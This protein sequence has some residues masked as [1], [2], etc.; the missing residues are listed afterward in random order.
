MSNY[1]RGLGRAVSFTKDAAR[2]GL[3]EDP[4]DAEWD[5]VSRVSSR[6]DVN[7]LRGG[8]GN[9]PG[10]PLGGGGGDLAPTGRNHSATSPTQQCRNQQWGGE[11]NI[12]RSITQQDAL[13]IQSNISLGE[14]YNQ[15]GR[16]NEEEPG[17]RPAE[18]TCEGG[19]ARALGKAANRNN[20]HTLER[21][22]E[23]QARIG[24]D[25]TRT[26]AFK[27]QVLNQ[28]VFRAFAFMKG[29][30]PTIH[31]VHSIGAFFGLS[32]MATDVQGKQIVFV[33]DRVQ[34]RQPIPFILP[35]QNS[36][37]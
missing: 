17:H 15:R 3:A 1:L 37:A 20:E 29:K 30:S 31:M 2:R 22:L 26:I 36:W 34:G 32:G 10:L 21:E 13:D 5:N 27:E 4:L 12:P 28:Q 11:G 23:W 7:L 18:A 25:F 35:P 19:I 14:G 24:G 33:G 8:R 16:G 9:G 6:A